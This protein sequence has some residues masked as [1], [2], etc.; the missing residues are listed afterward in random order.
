MVTALRQKLKTATL[1]LFKVIQQSRPEALPLLLESEA[2]PWPTV[3]LTW[4]RQSRN[5]RKERLLRD[6]FAHVTYLQLEALC[7]S[8]DA[9]AT[10][11]FC[12][13]QKEQVSKQADA[14]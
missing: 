7:W 9:D 3:L 2:N 14:K 1:D 11:A 13:L 8:K 5:L 6:A 4:Q 10:E 12:F